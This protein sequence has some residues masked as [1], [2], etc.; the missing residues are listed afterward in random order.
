MSRCLLRNI[1]NYLNQILK[2]KYFFSE[3]SLIKLMKLRVLKSKNRIVLFNYTNNFI[4][5]NLHNISLFKFYKKNRQ[6]SL[7]LL[8]HKSLV[9][10]IYVYEEIPLSKQEY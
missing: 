10:D 1:L 7:I 2:S 6:H 9:T 4:I 3:I 5:I 8:I